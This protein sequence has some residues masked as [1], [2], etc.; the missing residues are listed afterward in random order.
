[1]FRRGRKRKEEGKEKEREGE[2]KRDSRCRT[3]NRG[4]RVWSS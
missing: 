2:K 3:M 1:M 4:R